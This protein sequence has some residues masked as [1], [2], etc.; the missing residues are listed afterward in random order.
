MERTSCWLSCSNKLTLIFHRGS[1]PGLNSKVTIY[2]TCCCLRCSSLAIMLLKQ[3]LKETS[4][5]G[6]DNSLKILCFL[7]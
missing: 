4:L 3:V 5:I 7:Y 6:L 2:D 1:M